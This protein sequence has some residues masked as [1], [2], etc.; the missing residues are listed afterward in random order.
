MSQPRK[1]E[2]R[3]LPVLN[4]DHRDWETKVVTT[5]FRF[6]SRLERRMVEV[7]TVHGLTVPQFDVLATLWHGEGI[8]Q[9]ELAERLLVTKGNVVGL[10]DRIS[11]AGWVER[12]AD[13]EDRRANRLYLTDAGRQVLAK[14]QP[15]LAALTGKVFGTL[16]EAELRQMHA[17]LTRM[18]DACSR[19][20]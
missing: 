1:P 19:P 5:L 16:A 8:T 2:R 12:R 9:Q 18:E 7:L 13:P 15:Y 17:F 6:H 10:I 14:A 3:S 11:A 4:E 20:D